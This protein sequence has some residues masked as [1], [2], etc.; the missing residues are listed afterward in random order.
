MG[1]IWRRGEGCRRAAG[2][3]PARPRTIPLN[4]YLTNLELSYVA[5]TNP[6]NVEH[7]R[8]MLIDTSI[9][10]VMVKSPIAMI[11]VTDRAPLP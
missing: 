8:S 6:S 9:D 1:D 11:A 10:H 2:G 4:C 3:P 5:A 7:L